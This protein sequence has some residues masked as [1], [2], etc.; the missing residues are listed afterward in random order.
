MIINRNIL[1]ILRTFLNPKKKKKKKMKLYTKWTSI[2]Y[3]TEF[4]CKSLNRKKIF[5]ELF[6]PSES[7]ISL[8]EIIKSI[9]S[10]ANIKPPGNG[11]LTPEFYTHFSNKLAPVLSGIFDSWGKLEA[12]SVTYWRGI[13]FAIRAISRTNYFQ[14]T[15]GHPKWKELK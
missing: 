12:M 11:G 7:E 13:I 3:T 10:E 4:V 1:A 9:I 8:D 14:E 6:N 2:A 15:G 5:Y